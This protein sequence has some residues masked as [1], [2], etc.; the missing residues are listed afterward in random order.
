[1]KPKFELEPKVG[2]LRH[3][4]KYWWYGMSNKV[5]WSPQLILCNSKTFFWI[6]SLI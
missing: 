5:F 4:Y 3:A 6:S 2:T 1:V